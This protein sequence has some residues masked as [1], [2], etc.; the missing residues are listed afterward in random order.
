MGNSDPYE[1][2]ST[3]IGCFL[4]KL[5]LAGPAANM[6]GY[7]RERRSLEKATS[8]GHGNSVVLHSEGGVYCFKSREHPFQLHPFLR[9]RE[10]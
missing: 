8:I 6:V 9:M 7:G 5:H 2:D 10:I 4:M 1:V 3:L